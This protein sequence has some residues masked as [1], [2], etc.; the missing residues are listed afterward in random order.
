MDWV[1]A[2]LSMLSMELFRRRNRYGFIS[3]ILTSLCFAY[4]Q[5]EYN[6]WGIQALNGICVI[7]SV[8]GFIRWGGERA[9]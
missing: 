5:W 7:Q 1:G 4:V 8:F 3:L 6:L 9:C 2:A